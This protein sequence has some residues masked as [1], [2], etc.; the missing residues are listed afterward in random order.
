L[1]ILIRSINLCQDLKQWSLSN[2][3]SV[4][5]TDSKNKKEGVFMINFNLARF[6]D[7]FPGDSA[8][9]MWKAILVYFLIMI[10]F[11]IG[12]YVSTRALNS[13]YKDWGRVLFGGLIWFCTIIVLSLVFY[14]V[15]MVAVYFTVVAWY[16]EAKFLF[17]YTWVKALAGW[18][19]PI[20]VAAALVAFM[21]YVY[22][23]AA[24]TQTLLGMPW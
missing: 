20:L 3:I 19:V 9:W 22:P 5:W 14:Q 12:N 1:F 18:L 10:A 6:E 4:S 21:F 13:T 24:W 16:F 2:R 15:P 17:D 11:A 8:A 7:M 23:G